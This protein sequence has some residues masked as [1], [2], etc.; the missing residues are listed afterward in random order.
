MVAGT[1]IGSAIAAFYASGYSWEQMLTILGHADIDSMLKVRPSRKG[2]IPA[3]GYTDLIR[4]CTKNIP[5]E[6][7]PIPLKIVAVD[8][9][10]WKKVI[11]D[12]G[13]TA[14]AVRAS[15]AIPG[16]FT[17]VKMGDMLLADGYLLD[18]C[19]GGVVRQM[20]ADIVVAI[21][22]SFPTH[23]EPQNIVD[24]INRS[25]AIT[26]STSQKIDADFIF[27]PITEYQGSLNTKMV[28][29]YFQMGEECGAAHIGEL[30]QLIDE[31]A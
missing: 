29:E 14:T 17:P 13:D 27:K 25:L 15:S 31:F 21:S 4:L 20:G 12:R 22:L 3:T 1:S 16:V 24:I 26:T 8:L 30:L 28:G 9:V 6:K 18:N 23:S 11:F 7:M 2:L 5:I 19:P 10:S